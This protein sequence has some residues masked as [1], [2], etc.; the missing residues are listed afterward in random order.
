MAGSLFPAVGA[1][2]VGHGAADGLGAGLDLGHGGLGL[3]PAPGLAVLGLGGLEVAQGFKKIGDHEGFGIRH[4]SIV[5]PWSN[6][7]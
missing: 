4:A 6:I 5:P 2:G 1:A 7:P 3:D